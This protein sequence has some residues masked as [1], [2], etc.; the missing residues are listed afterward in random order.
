MACYVCNSHNH[1]D[2]H[3][4]DP[5]SPA[6]M[7]LVDHCKVPKENH[8]GTFPSNFCIKIIGT[9]KKTGEHL[10]IRT[11]VLE[12][13]NSQCGTFQFENDTL[14]GCILTCD[15]DGCNGSPRMNS[16]VIVLLSLLVVI[17]I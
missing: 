17:V 12:D 6:Y 3:C 13:M 8:I 16:N 5:M 9:S 10:V 4:D 2:P 1:S 11:C 15:Y 7:K 14:K